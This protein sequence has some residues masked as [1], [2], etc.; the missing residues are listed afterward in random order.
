MIVNDTC[1]THRSQVPWR[2]SGRIKGG[3]MTVEDEREPCLDFIC[4]LC[5][6]VVCEG[7]LLLFCVCLF[8]Y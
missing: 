1:A 6:A 7:L 8:Y 3:A 4:V 5:A 2:S